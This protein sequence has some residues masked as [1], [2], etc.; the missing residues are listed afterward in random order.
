[1]EIELKE[2]NADL[3]FLS[4]S[5][6]DPSHH[7]LLRKVFLLF[8]FRIYIRTPSINLKDSSRVLSTLLDPIMN[9]T[10]HVR[11]FRIYVFEDSIAC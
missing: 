9:L 4:Q 2:L 11:Y 10:K 3:Q 8:Q 6:P 1:M 7:A 5:L